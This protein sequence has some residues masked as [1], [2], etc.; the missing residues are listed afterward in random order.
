MAGRMNYCE[1]MK[2]IWKQ[3]KPVV[4]KD[5]LKEEMKSLVESAVD[6]RL[7]I[8]EVT[9]NDFKS[10]TSCVSVN[11]GLDILEEIY[12][13]MGFTVVRHPYTTGLLIKGW[14]E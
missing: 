9:I 7:S 3:Y 10:L 1:R 5:K 8:V 11:W 12:Q 2:K 4:D 6:N 13:E 14:T